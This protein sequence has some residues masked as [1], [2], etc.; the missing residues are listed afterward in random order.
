M[1][2]L[3]TYAF[4]WQ[5]SWRASQ[6]LSLTAM[7]RRTRAAGVGLFQICDYPPLLDLDAVG[8]GKLR[9]ESQ[10]LGIALELGARGVGE[11]TLRRLLDIA[12]A[13]DARLVR[14]MVNGPDGRPTLR[15]AERSLRAALPAYRDAGVTLALETYEQ[16]PSAQL[17]RLVE[18]VGSESLGICLDPAN[19]VAA[20]EHPRDVVERCAPYTVNVHV[21]DFAFTRREGLVG[22]TLAGAPLGTGLLDYRHLDAAVRRRA[23]LTRIVEH[24]V[25]WQGTYERT[26]RLEQEWTEASLTYLK[27][28][29]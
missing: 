23:G 17:V 25:P 18:A 16:V 8:L 24:W 7:L 2:G 13:L 15:E 6:P 5:W 26:A 29:T 9:E 20:L 28:T 4:F 1:I 21:K 10:D 22:F 27:E 3:G 12:E 11:A 19:C 14:S